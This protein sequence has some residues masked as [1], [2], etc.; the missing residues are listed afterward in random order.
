[1][2]R[3]ELIAKEGAHWWVKLP[4]AEIDR[5]I[6][7]SMKDFEKRVIEWKEEKNIQQMTADIDNIDDVP[8]S[9]DNQ[10]ERLTYDN[11]R[12]LY[13]GTAV[14][15][16]PFKPDLE[17]SNNRVLL[18]LLQ[19]MRFHPM[20]MLQP[21]RS[22]QDYGEMDFER[23]T[24]PYFD[25]HGP[26]STSLG[27]E[28]LGC[29]RGWAH[30]CNVLKR[31]VPAVEHRAKLQPP[32]SSLM[33]TRVGLG[34]QP[35]DDAPEETNSTT[36]KNGKDVPLFSAREIPAIKAAKRLPL[37]PFEPL[38]S[39]SERADDIVQF[40][41]E[42]IS[43]KV[44]EPPRPRD[45]SKVNVQ[46]TKKAAIT[47]RAA[48]PIRKKRSADE[49]TQEDVDGVTVVNKCGRCR[50]VIDG[51]TGCVQCRRAQLVINMS[52]EETSKPESKLLQVHTHML[53]RVLMKENI[54]EIQ[55]EGDEAVANHILRQRWTPYAVLP[56]QTIQAPDPTLPKQ[57]DD[58]EDVEE[59]DDNEEEHESEEE[60]NE[61]VDDEKQ[62]DVDMSGVVDES[63]ASSIT[64]DNI[65]PGE[66][67]KESGAADSHKPV[68]TSARIVAQEHQSQDQDGGGYGG[69]DLNLDQKDRQLLARRNREEATELNKKCVSVAC[70]G[71]LL[72]M[73][74]RDP[75]LL[76]AEPVQAEGYDKIIKNPIWFGK[77]KKEI[78][79]NNYT[80][81]SFFL[82]AQLLC[83]NAMVY[84]PPDSIYYKTARELY[85]LLIVMHKRAMDWMSAIKEAHSTAW[86]TA[87]KAKL[88]ARI[89]EEQAPHF[90]DPS[91]SSVSSA[92]A[93]PPPPSSFATSGRFLVDDPFASL[94]KSWPEAID[95]LRNH[96]YFRKSLDLDFLR[97][98]E[99][100]TAYYG[101][102]AVRRASTASA[103][104]LA[105]YPD[106]A[107]IY[108]LVG[109]RTH[110]E[111]ENLRNHVADKVVQ[112]VE[113][114]QLKDIPTWREEMIMRVLRKSQGRRTE[115][116]IGSVNGCARCDGMRVDTELKKA[117]NAE[118][119]RWGRT[120]RKPN[121]VPRV[122]SSRLSL[123]TGLGSQN[124]QQ[125]IA[126]RKEEQ[127]E[128]KKQQQQEKGQRRDSNGKKSSSSSSSK[129]TTSSDN[130]KALVHAANKA[131]E[132]AVTVRGSRIHGMGLYADQPFKKGDVVA[133]YIGEYVTSAV[134]DA[135]EK[136]YREERIQ[137]Y[138]FRIDSQLV[139]DATKLGG[140]GRYIN[141]S[142]DPNCSA[143]IVP[144]AF[145]ENENENETGRRW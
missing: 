55:T 13:L 69:L 9:T 44:P 89:N 39:P 21:D 86:K 119:I 135:R 125:M 108:N 107:G 20:P 79:A 35:T 23:V 5:F 77:M 124:T 3:N 28:C 50:T 81:A 1:M 46:E 96:D 70:C 6:S 123:S 31:R 40:V 127:D 101:S 24:I 97:T 109:R 130:I 52:R 4:P 57:K 72:A 88:L 68:R 30:L 145:N 136:V 73:M 56:P 112:T 143:K 142:C 78:L 131:N 29:A 76:F 15:A 115:G 27:D 7:M 94:R 110:T 41:E 140:H 138:Q 33:A 45:P 141:H 128:F 59:E 90:G 34:F 129:S 85:D 111:D 14:G 139:I 133:E 62:R 106:S 47:S 114:P 51:D 22:D 103:Y 144:Y 91:A 26:V 100:E 80:F 134:T 11:H 48:L 10:D 120:R 53:G 84:N 117:M 93:S 2:E 105:P 104:S 92:A 87:D 132:A 42:A 121:Q 32:L 67:N 64:S 74:R 37:I 12:R 83:D 58:D 126:K 16:K 102:L 63:S 65:N 19:D 118:N 95:M 122:D 98:K 36:E 61:N 60:Q 43:M 25:V 71:I 18:E 137:D 99:N 66:Y 116:M 75:L 38:H 82:D 8:D 49:I 54:G 17:E 113:P